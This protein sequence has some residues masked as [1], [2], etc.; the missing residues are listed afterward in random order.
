MWRLDHSG[1]VLFVLLRLSVL[2]IINIFFPG[3]SGV[4]SMERSGVILFTFLVYFSR[5]GRWL[6]GG[7]HSM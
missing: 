6:L 5:L 3:S 1:F 4:I 7:G 2:F